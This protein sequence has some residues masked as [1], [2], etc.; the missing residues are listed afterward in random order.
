MSSSTQI[1]LVSLQGMDIPDIEVVLV[2]GVLSTIS[3][4][5]Q[6]SIL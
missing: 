4:Y 2:Y 5:Y 3:Q 6:V 1:L